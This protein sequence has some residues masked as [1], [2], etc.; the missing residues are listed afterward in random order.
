MMN[1]GAIWALVVVLLINTAFIAGIA[2]FLF[3]LHRK[4]DQ[5]SETVHP[6]VDRV[7]ETLVKVETVTAQVSEQVNGI[8]DR[9]GHL[10][11]DVTQK[12]ETTTSIAEETIAQPLIGAASLMAGLSRG[13]DVYRS[14][15]AREKG[16][17]QR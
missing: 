17:G 15:S 6:L 7:N 13:W 11:E 1:Q 12:V 8:L 3:L 4:I 14:E 5:V 16:D 10:V 9:T 2:A